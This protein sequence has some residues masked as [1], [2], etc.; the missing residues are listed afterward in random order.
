MILKSIEV[1]S[2]AP[3]GAK[4]VMSSGCQRQKNR[5]ETKKR[6][7]RGQKTK[8][9]WMCQKAIAVLRNPLPRFQLFH[10]KMKNLIDS[11]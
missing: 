2:A 3:E 9:L 1:A 6:T 8:G 5:K 11:H 7:F 10:D 4:V